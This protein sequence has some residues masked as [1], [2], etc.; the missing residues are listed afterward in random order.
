MIDM[1]LNDLY[2]KSRAFILVPVMYD[3]LKTVNSNFCLRML[4]LA[5]M[6]SCIR[7]RQTDEYDRP[8]TQQ[9]TTLGRPLGLWY[10]IQVLRRERI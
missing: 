1:T 10:T 6:H 9:P 4:R 7:H 2:A 5:I 3:F 8:T